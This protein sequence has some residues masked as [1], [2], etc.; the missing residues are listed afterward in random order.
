MPAKTRSAISIRRSGIHGRGVYAARPIKSGERIV[1]YKGERINWKE[2]LRRHPHDPEQPNHTFYFTIGDDLVIDG[3]ARGNAARWI[4]H[5]C[6]PNCEAD[7]VEI[8][9]HM[10]V[11]IEAL[12]D[13]KTGEE[14]SYD[15]GLEI[16][17]PYTP[18]LKREFACSCGH[19]GCRGTMLAPKKRGRKAA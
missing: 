18:K 12:R 5:S 6:N 15:Y 2:A 9:G 16:D 13:I 19:K 14:L 10:H 3:G 1:E 11:F 8:R 7:M 4:N 17:A